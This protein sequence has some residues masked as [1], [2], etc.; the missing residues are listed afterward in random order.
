MNSKGS[1]PWSV[2]VEDGPVLL[3]YEKKPFSYLLKQVLDYLAAA[4]LLILLSPVMGLVALL[5]KVSSPGPVFFR[6]TRAGR[7]NQPFTVYK[8]RTMIAGADKVSL[9]IFKNDPRITRIGRLLRITSLD[10]L[11][12]LINVLRGE[13]SLIGP[14]PLLP[15]TIKLEERRR[16]GMK[17]GLTSYPVL[18][19]RHGLDW[20]ERMRL[21][22]WY[23]DHWSLRLDLTIMLKTIPVIWSRKNV[24]ESRMRPGTAP[25]PPS[26]DSAAPEERQPEGAHRP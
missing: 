12:Q 25:A 3:G 20:D 21:D 2:R 13:M 7:H 6:Q 15:D 24:D 16:Q 22:L 18:F 5:I 1:E 19:G 17:P 14:R 8:F 9:E 23:V 11:P 10:E 4:L 26:A